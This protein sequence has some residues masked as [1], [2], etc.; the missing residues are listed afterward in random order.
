MKNRGQCSG[1]SGEAWANGMSLKNKE[2]FLKVWKVLLPV[3][4]EFKEK[5]QSL[6]WLMMEWY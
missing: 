1:N 6:A 4:K 2:D 5:L 3:Y